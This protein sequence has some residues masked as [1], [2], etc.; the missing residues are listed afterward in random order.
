M[1]KIIRDITSRSNPVIMQTAS[2]TMSKRRRETGLFIFEGVKL[3]EEA[4]LAGLPIEYAVATEAAVER[5]AP[6]ISDKDITVYAV[7]EHCFEK[8]STEK[9][10]EGIVAVAKQQPLLPVTETE[11]GRRA[12]ILCDVQDA[13]NLGTMIRTVKALSDMDVVLC[14]ACADVFGHKC[15]RASMGA[16]FKQRIYSATDFSLCARVY[17]KRGLHLYAAALTEKAVSITDCDMKNCCAVL[18][19]EGHGLSSEIVEQCE[20]MI[21]PMLGME[22]LNVAAAAAITVWEMTGKGRS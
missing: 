15:V 22:S 10:P 5:L 2:L 9:A 7:P 8:V 12:I 13:G 16:V 19:N 21:I 18:G 6:L 17:K 4:L 11:G 3:F 1:A 14:G 20:P